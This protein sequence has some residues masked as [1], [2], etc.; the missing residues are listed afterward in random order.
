SVL[1]VLLALVADLLLL[2]VQRLLTP[3]T[4]ATRAPRAARRRKPEP[5]APAPTT[6]KG[7]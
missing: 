2:G 4:R 7:A 3:W 1:C 5:A 6:A